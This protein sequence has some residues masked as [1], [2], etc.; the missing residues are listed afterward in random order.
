MGRT[1][2]DLGSSSP[3]RF[4]AAAVLGGGFRWLGRPSDAVGSLIEVL[5]RTAEAGNVDR[6]DVGTRIEV[7]GSSIEC[8]ESADAVLERGSDVV[9]RTIEVVRR[10]VEVVGSGSQIRG[11][12]AEVLG[13]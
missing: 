9:G 4:P 13:A 5:R 11:S 2:A 6:G 7:V 12:S 8:W 3:R 1:A 10:T